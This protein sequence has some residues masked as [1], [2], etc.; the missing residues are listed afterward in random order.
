MSKVIYT[1]IESSG[2]SLQ[3]AVKAK[4]VLARNI[5][6]AKKREKMGVPYVQ[7]TMAF[8][9]PMSRHFIDEVEKA[10]VKY[11]QFK[12]LDEI[13]HLNEVDIFIDELIKFFPASGSNSL[14]GEQLDFITQGAKS[15]VNMY[16]ASQDLSQVHKQFRLLT[17]EVYVVT[18]LI[19]SRRPMKS[20]PPVKTIWGICMLRSVYPSSFKGDSASMESIGIIPSF[21]FINEK[22][23]FL[24]DTSYKVPVSTLPPKKVRKQMLIGYDENGE[25]E[26]EKVTWV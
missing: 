25:K 16:C 24:F 20:S 10:G 4:E 23:C 13:L 12:N 19:G 5:R 26:F 18:K 8:V 9:S 1:G 2:K 22:D 14:S 21:Y 15:G 7:R 6:W 17:N 11:M 3:L